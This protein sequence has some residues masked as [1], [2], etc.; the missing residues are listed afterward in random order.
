[1]VS[2]KSFKS[3][4][5]AFLWKSAWLGEMMINEWFSVVSQIDTQKNRIGGNWS[6][7]H[8]WEKY[9]FFCEKNQTF[10]IKLID[11]RWWCRAWNYLYF[12]VKYFSRCHIVYEK[13]CR[14]EQE[15]KCQTVTET[16][17][18]Q[19]CQMINEEICNTINEQNCETVSDF[20]YLITAQL[21]FNELIALY[22]WQFVTI[23]QRKKNVHSLI[24]R[25][26][27]LKYTPHL[28]MTCFYN[29]I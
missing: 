22:F 15:E 6:T 9:F 29:V 7:L 23:K 24:K 11:D 2:F 4:K 28:P 21:T 8:C 16:I 12:G 14:N 1:M 25:R 20:Q 18:Q 13:D 27:I 10:G 19:Q 26:R 17:T 5:E 3:F